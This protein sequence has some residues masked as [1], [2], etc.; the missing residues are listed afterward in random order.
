MAQSVLKELQ[1]EKK[2]I[3]RKIKFHK[4]T[5]DSILFEFGVFAKWLNRMK[6]NSEQSHSKKQGLQ[7]ILLH[8]CVGMNK[9]LPCLQWLHIAPM[10]WLSIV[11]SINV[12]LNKLKSFS[13][14]FLFMFLYF[15]FV[16]LVLHGW[17]LN[18]RTVHTNNITDCKKKIFRISWHTFCLFFFVIFLNDKSQSCHF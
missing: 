15:F 1:P 3:T 11:E 10:N 5:A 4:F 9:T 6:V 2:K 7:E 17:I 14:H 18:N 12:W 13:T 8:H 16:K